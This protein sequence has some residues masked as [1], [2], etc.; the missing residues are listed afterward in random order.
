MSGVLAEVLLVS[1]VC[2]CDDCA[3]IESIVLEA[4]ELLACGFK[5]GVGFWCECVA[6]WQTADPVSLCVHCHALGLALAGAVTP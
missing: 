4:D 1:P 6:G 5:P 2:T 3:A